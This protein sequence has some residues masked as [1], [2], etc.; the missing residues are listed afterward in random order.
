MP[1]AR[2][3]DRDRALDDA[4]EVFW[5]QGYDATSVQDLV[6]AM[7]VNRGSLYDTFGR[8]HD[9]FLAAL[10]RYDETVCESA[11]T[12]LDEPGRAMEKV[13]LFFDGVIR[14]GLDDA[15]RRGCLFVNSATEVAAHDPAARDLINGHVRRVEQAFAKILGEGIAAG[16]L[17]PDLDVEAF[18]G[19]LIGTLI[20]IRTLSRTDPRPEKLNA[21]AQVAISALADRVIQPVGAD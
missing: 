12:E 4:V 13:R 14:A 9:L 16:E 17:D 5:S 6:H 1:R 11:L 18:A 7:G 2:Q 15:E 8:K 20:G 10:A 21:I 19:F 3:F